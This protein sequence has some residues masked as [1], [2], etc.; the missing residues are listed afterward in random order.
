[1]AVA[2]V[3]QGRG[4]AECLRESGVFPELLV[5]MTGVGEESGNMEGTL[6]VIGEYY[7]SE[8]NVATTRLLTIMEPAITIGLA[9]MTVFLLLS[10]YL[11]MFGMYSGM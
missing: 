7:D 2:G 6:D 5:E 8:V 4:I 3:E 9:V 1:M 11:P 10:V